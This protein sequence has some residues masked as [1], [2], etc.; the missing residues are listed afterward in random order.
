[1]KLFLQAALIVLLLLPLSGYG[2]DFQPKVKSRLFSEGKMNSIVHEYQDAQKRGLDAPA[3]TPLDLSKITQGKSTSMI[4]GLIILV[5]FSDNVADTV[6]HGE[7]AFNELLFSTGTYATGSMNDYYLENSNQKVGIT[8]VITVWLRMPQLYSYYTNGQ[9]GFGNYPQNAQKLTE[10][11]VEAADSL[12]DFSQFDNDGDGYVDA[13]FV[14]HAGPG[15]ETTGSNNDIHSHAW[16]ISPQ[17][18]DGVWIQRYSMEPETQGN[19]LTTMGVFA[20]EFGHVLGLPDLY[21]TDYSSSGVGYWSVMSGGSWGGPPGLGGATPV[22]FD[23]WCKSRL[24]WAKPIRLTSDSANVF[25]PPIEGDSTAYR[26]WTNGDVSSQYFLAE[27]RKRTGF[28]TYVPGEGLLLWHVD[29]NAPNNT[30][31]WH[32]KVDLEQADGYFQLNSGGNSGDQGDPFPGNTNNTSFNGLTTPNSHDYDDQETLVAAMNISDPGNGAYADFYVTYPI[33]LLDFGGITVNDSLG[34]N[35]GDLDPGEHVWLTLELENIGVDAHDVSISLSCAQPY[36]TLIDSQKTVS[37]VSSGGIILKNA[38]EI[39]VSSTASDP[40]YAR[41]TVEM[42]NNDFNKT[43]AYVMTIGDYPGFYSDMES[44]DWVW[45]H[46][47]VTSGYGDQWTVSS[48]RNFTSGGHQSY[49][50]GQA[51][52]SGTYASSLYA[53]LES[54]W[55]E[56]TGD[57]TLEFATWYDMEASTTP[58]MAYDGGLVEITYDGVNYWQLTPVEGY[59]HQI[60][61]NPASPFQ[62]GTLVFSGASQE[63]QVYHVNLTNTSGQAKIRFVFGS[64]AASEGEGWY[65]DDVL[66]SPAT[67]VNGEENAP[68]ASGFGIAGNYPNPFNPSTTIQFQTAK[69]GPAQLD[70]YNITGQKVRT[71]LDENIPAGA[72]EVRWDGRSDTGRMAGSGMYFVVLK[73]GTQR[74]VRKIMLVK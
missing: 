9:A 24:G 15:R 68:L 66:L 26:L 25:V 48:A 47:P 29:E 57:M 19:H 65:I 74:S 10:D 42:H 6:N 31:D 35:G 58:G 62:A 40:S 67:V 8:G 37:V 16:S 45:S 5:D 21:D 41:F 11:A 1:M 56:L 70:I 55:I 60:I 18:R 71:L 54:P 49:K 52:S 7:A 3:G 51:G 32:R 44:D 64:D 33:P 4:N 50:L 53:A 39:E 14:V 72:A 43:T 38:F 27:Y 17:R 20:H 69:A 30:N 2:V 28:D 73:A 46:Y 63:W 22:H 12:V 61:S 59:T 23:V 36:V 34:D 13:L